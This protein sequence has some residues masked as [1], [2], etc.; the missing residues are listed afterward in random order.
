MGIMIAPSILSADFSRLGDEIRAVEEAG[1]DAIHVDVMDGRF[2]PNL[3][4]GP[5][6][7][8]AIR[9]VTGLPLDVHLMIE[10]PDRYIDAFAKAGASWITVHVEACTHLHRTIQ[11]IKDL[12]IKAGAV[13]NPATPP[14]TLEYCLDELDLILVMSVNPGFGGQRFIPSALRKTEALRQMLADKG[15][16]VAIEVDGGINCDT[17]FDAARAGAEIFVAGSA[18]FGTKNYTKAIE[19]LKSLGDKGKGA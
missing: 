16:S 7:V 13:L 11:K 4:I 18:I 12:G 15:L 9:P 6:V 10:A 3:T 19:K 17:I 8:E 1:A 5:M 2:V 14:S